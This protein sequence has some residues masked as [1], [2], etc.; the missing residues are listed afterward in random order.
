MSS[1]RGFDFV[2]GDGSTVGSIIGS[3]EG[4]T[5]SESWD[6]SVTQIKM[7]NKDIELITDGTSRFEVLQ[8]G[9]VG[10]G[11]PAPN[12][13]LSIAPSALGAKLTLWDGGINTDHYGFGVSSLQ[14]N[15]HVAGPSASHVF[16]VG[17]KKWRWHRTDEDLGQW[18]YHHKTAM[19]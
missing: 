15:Y 12:T 11:T 3:F 10:I 4:M 6:G 18:Q 19:S 2:R 17:G 8:N 5:L 16:Y 13:L 14:Q 1:L 7:N 9:N